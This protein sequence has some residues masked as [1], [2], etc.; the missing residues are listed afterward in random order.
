[1]R[2]DPVHA[3]PGALTTRAP[4]VPPTYSQVLHLKRCGP[5]PLYYQLTQSLEQAVGTGLIAR[6]TRLLAEKDMARELNVAA[7]TVCN[8][9]AYLERRGVL[10][11]HRHPG[12]VVR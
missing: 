12:T 10:T 2:A 4:G 5:E 7:A 1:M 9:W 6:G 3:A 8:A 11:R